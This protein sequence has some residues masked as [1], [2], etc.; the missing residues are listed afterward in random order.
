MTKQEENRRKPISLFNS[1]RRTGLYEIEP[2][3]RSTPRSAAEVRDTLRL[4]GFLKL[5]VEKDFAPESLIE[6][7]KTGIRR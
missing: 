3:D 6:A 2:Y 4:K 7:I 5:A 1:P